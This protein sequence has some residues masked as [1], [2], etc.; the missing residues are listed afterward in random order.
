MLLAVLLVLLALLFWE[1]G[2]TP[3]GPPV[4]SS[5]PNAVWLRHQWVGQ[6][7]EEE[8]Y[9]VLAA[10][11]RDLRIS[12]AYFHAGPIDGPGGVGAGKY[13]H[14]GELIAYL[15]R[16][17][18]GVRVQAW[19]GQLTIQGGGPLDL[20]NP[21]VRATLL[22]AVRGVLSAGFDGVHFDLEPIHSGDEPFLDLLREAGALCRAEG[23]SLSVAAS[24]PEP[25]AGLERFLRLFVRC[26]GCWSKEYFR[27]V[28]NRVDQVAVMAYDTGSPFPFVY[29]R[30]MAWTTAWC[31][32]ATD[33]QVLVG[34]PTYDYWSPSHY[35]PVEN[36][37]NGLAG[38]KMGLNR[39]SSGER[40]RVGVAVYAEWTT[41]RAEWAIY[42]AGWLGGEEQ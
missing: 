29:R 6:G 18:P 30:L 20:Q 2:L 23:K 38:V 3:G 12:D 14:A 39:L 34:V 31:A 37:A 11:L 40:A 42:R 13:P 22:T 4:F 33:A 9:A 15:K 36:L 32:G 8:E 7:H 17:C 19:L 41:S 24:R 28:A 35:P 5:G 16:A 27:Q 26:P 10:L 21:E 25:V 1:P